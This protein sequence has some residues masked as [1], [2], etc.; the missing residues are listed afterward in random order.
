MITIVT[1]Y[2]NREKFLPRTLASIAASNF[3]PVNLILVDN[4]STDGSRAICEQFKR[5]HEADDFSITLAEEPKRGACAARN[6]GLSLVNTNYVYFFDSDDELD[7]DFLSCVSPLAHDPVDLLAITTRM[8]KDGH[9]SVRQYEDTNEA[10]AQILISHLNTQAMII[11]TDIIRVAGGWDESAAIW[12]DW[13]L[14]VRLL[15]YSSHVSWYT[16]RPFHTLHVHS[17][18]LTGSDFSSHL[19]DY[20]HTMQLVAH[21][22]KKNPKAMKAL[23]LRHCIFCGM[24]GRER[25][26]AG[27]KQ[28]E[29]QI[30]QLFPKRSFLMDKAG[31]YV[32]Q[33]VTNKGRGAWKMAL[34]ASRHL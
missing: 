23:F 21:D 16:E 29:A 11:R 33:Y 31:K 12:N 17:D 20:L 22:V 5:E 9:V 19:A 14:G 25:N 30:E 10:E 4:G 7:P 6:K 3:R 27:I 13:E 24:L 28:C 32:R 26:E 34:W 8:E 15:S 1:P 2:Y 18:S